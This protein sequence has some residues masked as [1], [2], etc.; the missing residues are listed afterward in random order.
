MC[1]T[2]CCCRGCPDSTGRDRGIG[3]SRASTPSAR[4]CCSTWTLENERLYQQLRLSEAN[5]RALKADPHGRPEL[6]QGISEDEW[7]SAWS[8]FEQL[9]FARLCHYLRARQPD[10][11]PGYSI[12]VYRLDQAEIDAALNGDLRQLGAAIERALAAPAP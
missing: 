10:A 6:R 8:R 2:P 9:R 3:A 5:F 1:P 12:L 7:A 11:Q 4:P